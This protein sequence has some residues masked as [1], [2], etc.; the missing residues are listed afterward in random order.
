M[1]NPFGPGFAGPFANPYLAAFG[2]QGAAVQPGAVMG[3]PAPPPGAQDPAAVAAASNAA[4]LLGLE[5]ALEEADFAAARIATPRAAGAALYYGGGAP[6]YA[7][8]PASGAG[9][10]PVAPPLPPHAWEPGPS[11]GG[12]LRCLDPTHAAP[13]GRVR[14]PRAA[15]RAA[16]R[17]HAAPARVLSAPRLPPRLPR[18]VHARAAARGGCLL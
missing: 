11:A 15:A 18:A 10:A 2:M 6:A 3:W 12:R 17:A 5:W 1:A 7:G 4:A 16:P 8:L 9:L 14:A 13:C